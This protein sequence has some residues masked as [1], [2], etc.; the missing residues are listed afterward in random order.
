[1]T[2]FSA[3]AAHSTTFT[4]TGNTLTSIE[5]PSLG[6]SLDLVLVT[7]EPI[8]T[9]FTGSLTS[10]DFSSVTATAVGGDPLSLQ[11]DVSNIVDFD[12]VQGQVSYAF[13]ASP[14]LFSPVNSYTE[15]S[16]PSGAS[17]D[18]IKTFNNSTR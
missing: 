4:Y 10:S 15:S 7:N 5:K 12:L 17:Y 9:D 8:A 18:Q 3:S 6:T 14:Y 16:D 11:A 2:L 13:I 1:L